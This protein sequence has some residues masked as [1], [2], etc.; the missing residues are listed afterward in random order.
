MNTQNTSG[1]QNTQNNSNTVPS[2]TKVTAQIAESVRNTATIAALAGKYGTRVTRAQ[3]KEYEKAHSVTLRWVARREAP[4]QS[5]RTPL[6]LVR[7]SGVRGTYAIPA[8]IAVAEI[9]RLRTEDIRDGAA[10]LTPAPALVVE[11]VG[12][13]TVAA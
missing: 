13:S 7:V 4:V 3:I 9:T 12:D 5:F 6:G 2:A 10:V 11:P 1:T 8:A